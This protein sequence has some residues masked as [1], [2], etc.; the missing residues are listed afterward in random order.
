MYGNI[1]QKTGILCTHLGNLT[2]LTEFAVQVT[3]YRTQGKD[4][5]TRK[6]MVQR[7]FFDWIQMNGRQPTIYL[8]VKFAIFGRPDPA[9]SGFP[10]FQQAIMRAE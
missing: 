2:I 4:P 3:P 10:V 6:E 1:F 7:L 8:C 9:I 5:T